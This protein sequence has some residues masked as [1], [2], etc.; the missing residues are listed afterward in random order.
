MGHSKHLDGWTFKVRR[1]CCSQKRR[2][3]PPIYA[4]GAKKKIYIYLL[5]GY[6]VRCIALWFCICLDDF[7]CMLGLVFGPAFQQNEASLMSESDTPKNSTHFSCTLAWCVCTRTYMQI[8]I[9][10]KNFIF[11]KLV[12]KKTSFLTFWRVNLILVKFFKNKLQS[13]I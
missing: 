8:I 13:F 11:I 2:T 4:S 3:G 9:S 10:R 1:G 7:F 12:T 5:S 6:C